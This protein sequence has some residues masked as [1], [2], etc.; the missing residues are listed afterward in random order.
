MS[1]RAES[2]QHNGDFRII[3]DGINQTLDAIVEPLNMASECVNSLSQGTVP[4]KIEKQLNGD[5][6]IIK[7]NLNAC[8]DSMNRLLIDTN[9][10]ASA[11]E[12]GD[13]STRAD[14]SLHTGDFRKIIEAVNNALSLVIGPLDVATNCIER[15][16]KGD[17]PREIHDEWNGDFNKIKTNLNTCIHAINGLVADANMLSEAAADGHV[18]V[19]ADIELHQGNYRKIIEGVNATLETI[20]QPIVT[21]KNATLSINLA[22]ENIA[23]GNG[24]LARRTEEQASNLE[25]AAKRLDELAGTVNQNAAN[26]KQ[27]SQ[28]ALVA[29]EVAAKGGDVVG[30]VVMTMA[31]INESAR[32]IE[33]IISVIDSIAF[34]TNILALNAAVE[35][36][37]AGEQGRG[38]AVVAGEV[39]NLAQRSAS[40]AKEIKELIIDSVNRTTDGTVQVENAGKT[41]EEI[42]TSVQHVSSI[43]SEIA[44]ASLE[45]SS[46]I[47]EVNKAISNM[48]E[49]T[50][51]N[52]GLVKEAASAA[53]SLLTESQQLSNSVSVFNLGD[54]AEGELMASSR[55][56][57]TQSAEPIEVEEEYVAMA[58]TGTDDS[59]AWEEF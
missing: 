4:P 35:A 33:D 14:V 56:K 50:R 18:T 41:M 32:K 3:V 39:R 37:R 36:A 58:K 29:S 8:I 25:N 11:A 10:L 55:T 2:S 19:R 51:Q 24:N 5:F 46:G 7:D 43:I 49:V 13:L 52:A 40:A 30:R 21:V 17:L 42:V 27:A 16:S 6:N 48:E 9:L 22:S 57:P 45:Q 23:I 20:V 12:Q 47:N 31:S 28:L 44:A 38:F 54:L 15:I 53:A 34:Q 1:V 26:A 59:P